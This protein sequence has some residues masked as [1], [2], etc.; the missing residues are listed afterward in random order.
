MNQNELAPHL[1][2]LT[3]R[4]QAC[5]AYGYV[6]RQAEEAKEDG[7]YPDLSVKEVMSL[8]IYSYFVKDDPIIALERASNPEV[9]AA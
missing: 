1:Q 4:E 3:P 7:L 8:L 5:V 6:R 2:P 9:S